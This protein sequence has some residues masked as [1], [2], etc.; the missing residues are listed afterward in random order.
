M[1]DDNQGEPLL[2]PLSQRNVAEHE[3]VNRLAK[4]IFTKL[5][6]TK[7]TLSVSLTALIKLTNYT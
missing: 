1:E 5:M 6:M 7:K 4:T 3:N 2:L